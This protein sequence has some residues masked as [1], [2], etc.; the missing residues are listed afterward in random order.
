M[1]RRS[2]PYKIS[3]DETFAIRVRFAIPELGM[4]RLNEM[5]QWLRDRAPKAHAVHSASILYGSA[6]QLCAFLYV[7]DPA[8]ALECVKEFELQIAGLPKLTP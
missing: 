7:N 1:V 2:T 5:H 3:D 8:I 4:K 6:S